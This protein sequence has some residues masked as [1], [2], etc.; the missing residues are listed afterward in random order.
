MDDYESVRNV[1][2]LVTEEGLR[3]WLLQSINRKFEKLPEQKPFLMPKEV[4]S[5]LKQ[6]EP[7]E[8]PATSM[9]GKPK[10][11]PKAQVTREDIEEARSVQSPNFK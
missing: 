6:Y 9:S 7:K 11:V 10:H 1:T 8:R 5:F 4:Y 3:D 2:N